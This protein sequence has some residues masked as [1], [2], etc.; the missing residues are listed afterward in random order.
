MEKIAKAI[1]G[2]FA[3]ALTGGGGTGIAI[4]QIPAGAHLPDAVGVW[5]PVVNAI[6]GFI[7]GFV[8]VYFAPANKK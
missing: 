1:A 8:G 3:G 6:A 4:V 7:I 5:L 2:G